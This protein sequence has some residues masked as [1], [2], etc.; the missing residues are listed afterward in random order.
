[1]GDVIDLQLERERRAPHCTGRVFCLACHHE[2]VAVWP[3][4]ADAF[5]LECPVCG[6]QNSIPIGG[7]SFDGR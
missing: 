5:E 4:S 2:W 3:L 7:L 1:V 6:V